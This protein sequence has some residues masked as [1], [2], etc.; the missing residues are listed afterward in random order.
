MARR[1]KK[2]LKSIPVAERRG[3]WT[4]W[5]GEIWDWEELLIRGDYDQVLDRLEAADA[6]IGMD[7]DVTEA[8]LTSKQ[9]APGGLWYLLVELVGTDWLHLTH[10]LRYFDHFDWLARQVGVPLMQTG[11]Q[12]TAGSTYV[13]IVEGEEQILNFESTGMKDLDD[14]EDDEEDRDPCHV[15]LRFETELLSPDWPKQFKNEDEVQEALMREFEA[16]VPGLASNVKHGKVNLW[17]QHED[18]LD[19]RY[20]QRI[21]LL[22]LNDDEAVLPRA[23]VGDTVFSIG[24]QRPQRHGSAV[25]RRSW[26]AP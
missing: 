5:V 6:V 22:R 19:A 3:V 18:V 25:R 4:T 10:S 14:E 15:P 1:Y 23:G 7:R 21:A 24:S 8:V 12:D 2:R 11:L 17:A 13:K 9:S 26:R 16:Y 20:I